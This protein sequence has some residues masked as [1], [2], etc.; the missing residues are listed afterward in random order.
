M[1]V[2]ALFMFRINDGKIL[3]GGSERTGSS[4]LLFTRFIISRGIS[5]RFGDV[6]SGSMTLGCC[7]IAFSISMRLVM[8][9]MATLFTIEN[10]ILRL[11][12]IT[13]IIELLN[14]KRFLSITD[15]S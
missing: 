2:I 13:A 12:F 7:A 9:G 15:E 5:N 8:R 6:S 4:E 3:I 1:E 10:M 11:T 14:T